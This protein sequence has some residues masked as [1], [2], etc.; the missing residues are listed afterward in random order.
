MILNFSLIFIKY[1]TCKYPYTNEHALCLVPKR[2][3]VTGIKHIANHT[4]QP[5]VFSFFWSPSVVLE[6]LPKCLMISGFCLVKNRTLRSLLEAFSTWMGL[7]NYGVHYRVIW[8]KGF[9]G[10]P[11]CQY[12][13][14]SS[15]D[16]SD[17]PEKDLFIHLKAIY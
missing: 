3:K 4:Y 15:P 16:L 9:L 11:M 7:W 8:L 10:N 6:V 5:V 1:C 12:L 2:P 17:A 13:E 14:S